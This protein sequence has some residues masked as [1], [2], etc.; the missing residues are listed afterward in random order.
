MSC[1]Y[2][3]SF[4]LKGY[5]FGIL[6]IGFAV[7]AVGIRVVYNMRG[8]EYAKSLTHYI[9]IYIYIYIYQIWFDGKIFC[10]HGYKNIEHLI[11]K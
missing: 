3:G 5:S 1:D 6:V 9:Y 7:H 10:P 8:I 11:G 4:H 2:Y